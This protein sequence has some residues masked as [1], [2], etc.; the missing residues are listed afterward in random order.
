MKYQRLQVL[1]VNPRTKSQKTVR[2]HYMSWRQEKGMPER[3]DNAECLFFDTPLEWNKRPLQLIL[4]H[5]SGNSDDNSP[6]N[7]RLLCPN[8]D[9]QNVLTKGGANAGRIKRFES[10]SYHVKNRD[11]TQDAHAFGQLASI[12]LTPFDG[13]ANGNE[14]ND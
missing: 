1:C 8:C 11:G 13:Q 5:K 10:G 3:C 12:T 9:S 2:R 7:L 6:Q 4:D 14:A